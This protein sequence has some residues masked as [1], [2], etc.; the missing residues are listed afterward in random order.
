MRLFVNSW[1]QEQD[2]HE[3][4]VDG[5]KNNKI[6]IDLFVSGCLPSDVSPDSLVGKWVEVEYTHPYISIAHG[7]SILE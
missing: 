1:N 7:V 3:C 6:R 2:F 5:N 4:F